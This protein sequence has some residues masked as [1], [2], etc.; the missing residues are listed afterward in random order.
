MDRISAARVDAIGG[1]MRQLPPRQAAA[2]TSNE[3]CVRGSGDLA[4]GPTSGLTAVG[5]LSMMLWRFFLIFFRSAD[6]A[7]PWLV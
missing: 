6:G 2:T 5:L 4:A 7:A 1:P 3:V